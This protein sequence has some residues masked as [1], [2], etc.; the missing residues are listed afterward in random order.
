MT[1]LVECDAD[2]AVLRALGVPK[3][4]LLHFGG[5]GKVINRLKALPDAIGMVDE[6]PASAQARDLNNYQV[7]RQT[8]EG[9]RLLARLVPN[10]CSL[11]HQYSTTEA[12]I[13]QVLRRAAEPWPR[14]RVRP[15]PGQPV[16]AALL[17]EYTVLGRR[18]H[19]QTS[20]S[21]RPSVQ[22]LD[23]VILARRSP[24]SLSW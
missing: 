2:E 15:L 8:S 19:R 16:L 20:G 3:Q 21:K 22:R 1:V 10:Q 17:P 6:D 13:R 24:K 18:Q 23:G 5:K 9:L 11:V 12:V 4:Q 14:L 7:E